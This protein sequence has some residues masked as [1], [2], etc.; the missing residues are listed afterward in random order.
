MIMHDFI[1]PEERVELNNLE[2]T[3]CGR[4]AMEVMS[5]ACCTLYQLEEYAVTTD[6]GHWYCHSDCYRDAR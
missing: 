6:S 3:G 5:E 1:T 2:C 4:N